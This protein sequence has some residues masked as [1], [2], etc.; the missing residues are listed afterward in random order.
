M[1]RLPA[2]ASPRCRC[3]DS[4]AGSRSI[5]A[6]EKY[7]VPNGRDIFMKPYAFGFLFTVSYS[8]PVLR[9]KS[10]N[11]NPRPHGR[12]QE[13]F[14]YFHQPERTAMTECKH[15][16]F[17]NS[18]SAYCSTS[19]IFSGE[20][21]RFGIAFIRDCRRTDDTAAFLQRRSAIAT[22]SHADAKYPETVPSGNETH[23]GNPLL[24][25]PAIS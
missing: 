3:N 13:A 19:L 15:I 8:S 21:F 16:R 24:A 10:Q 11:D 18:K 7:P 22:S 1:S 9:L 14:D 20:R 4:A 5:H 12:A 23:A 25:L 6:S 2:S 17:A